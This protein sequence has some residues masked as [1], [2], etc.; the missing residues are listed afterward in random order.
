M[1]KF[2]VQAVVCSCL[3]LLGC[4]KSSSGGGSTG[5]GGAPQKQTTASPTS[6]SQPTAVQE[7][8]DSAAAEPRDSILYA[9]LPLAMAESGSQKRM[10]SGWG[11]CIKDAVEN[12]SEAQAM[13]LTELIDMS[14]PTNLPEDVE[15]APQIKLGAELIYAATSDAPNALNLVFTANGAEPYWVADFARLQTGDGRGFLATSM[16]ASLKLVNP[17]DGTSKTIDVS[18]CDPLLK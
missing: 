7:S 17:A 3:G 14:G 9:R 6:P 16:E 10:N 8:S 1:K 4:Q 13:G 12:S 5:L 2:L 15:P 11:K 18:A